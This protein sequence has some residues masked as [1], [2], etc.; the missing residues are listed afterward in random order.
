MNCLDR[1]YKVVFSPHKYSHD[2][3]LWLCFKYLTDT[4]SLIIFNIERASRLKAVAGNWVVMVPWPE[5]HWILLLSKMICLNIMMMIWYSGLAVWMIS[6]QS[7]LSML[8]D[9]NKESASANYSY[10]S[11]LPQTPHCLSAALPSAKRN[12]P[13][14]LL[15][16][17]FV[18]ITH[19]DWC[20]FEWGPLSAF[21]EGWLW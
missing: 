17:Q 13:S 14:L 2:L 7:L 6:L 20:R 10:I 9:Q 16:A 1:V 4:E 5:Q 21:T 19:S 12:T 15:A 3:H 18:K 8:K 11:V